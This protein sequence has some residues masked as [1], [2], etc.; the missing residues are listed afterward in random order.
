MSTIIGQ[1]LGFAS[2]ALVLAIGGYALFLGYPTEAAVIITGSA[3]AVI[4]AYFAR[5]RNKN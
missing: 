4:M 2:S 5:S 1:L 3:A